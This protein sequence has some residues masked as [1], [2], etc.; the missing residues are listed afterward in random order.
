MPIV[1]GTPVVDGEVAHRALA[2]SSRARGRA[3]GRPR[4]HPRGCRRRASPITP[5]SAH[6]LVPRRE[7]RRDRPV[8]GGLV[9]LAARRRE[10]RSPRPAAPSASWPAISGEVV[11]GRLLL[12]GPLA[13]RPGA[14]RRVA[15][16]GRVVDRLRAGASTASR[17][18][19][20]V[21]QLQSMP[22][23][24][25]AGSMSSA[26]SRLRTTRAR[27][28]SRTGARVNPQLP[29]TAVVTPCQHELAPS[30]SQNTWASRWVWPSMKPGRDDVA[31][32]VD[33]L[34]PRSPIRPTR[35]MRPP[36]TPTSAR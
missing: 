1:I 8:V 13:H 15:D 35:A 22:S 17:Y 4:P 25:A 34:A 16:V 20:K 31:L 9:V 18:S 24:S 14:Q 19:G 27:S 3:T 30:G 28:A 21:S 6:D 29:I 7:A 12:E 33:L 11:G 2:A 5:T 32:G 36:T 23:A 26:R 10:A